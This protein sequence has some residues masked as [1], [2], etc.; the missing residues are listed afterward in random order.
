M[1]GKKTKRRSAGEKKIIEKSAGGKKIKRE[2][3]G[4]RKTKKGNARGRRTKRKSA[5]GKKTGIL[6][7]VNIFIIVGILICLLAS[8]SFGYAS[9]CFGCSFLTLF[10]SF[11]S[12]ILF[13]EILFFILVVFNCSNSFHDDTI[14]LVQT[15]RPYTKSSICVKLS[16]R[17]NIF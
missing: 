4:G 12:P 2:S 10:L 3:V 17:S 11:Q 16:M 9:F 13:S 1:G 7:F 15:N 8:F 5:G 6:I 14:I